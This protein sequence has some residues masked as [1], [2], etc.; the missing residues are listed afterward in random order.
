MS[1][2]RWLSTSTG[3]QANLTAMVEIMTVFSKLTMIQ[4]GQR[5][6]GMMDIAPG[7]MKIITEFQSRYMPCVK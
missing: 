7:I 3:H 6:A 5:K 1:P 4:A 2:M